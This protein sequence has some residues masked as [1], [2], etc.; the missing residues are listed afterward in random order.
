MCDKQSYWVFLCASDKGKCVGEREREPRCWWMYARLHG[1]DPI[2]HSIKLNR[3][4]E[5]PHFC[6]E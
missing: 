6:T 3:K 4:V 5:S 2:F 1:D